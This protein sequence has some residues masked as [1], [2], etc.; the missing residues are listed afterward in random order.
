MAILLPCLF[1][2]LEPHSLDAN[3]YLGVSHEKN[4]PTK[5]YQARTYSRV[6]S[7]HGD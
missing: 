5:R 3:N 1:T 6:Q 4:I 2:R 7:S